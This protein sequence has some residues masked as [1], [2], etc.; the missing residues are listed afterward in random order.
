MR[1]GPPSSVVLD[2]TY[3]SDSVRLARGSRGSDF[4]F[5]KTNDPIANAWK[6]FVSVRP[7]RARRVG[8][9][10]L[11]TSFLVSS[12]AQRLSLISLS[13]SGA[14]LSVTRLLAKTIRAS[15]HLMSLLGIFL[16]LSRGGIER[17]N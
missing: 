13:T 1:I 4:V 16:V 2:T 5:I 14:L 6:E 12:A 7:F 3:L 10:M 9:A 17:D 8:A 15:G 11:L